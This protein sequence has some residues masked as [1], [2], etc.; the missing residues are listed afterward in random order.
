MH[1]GF[2]KYFMLSYADLRSIHIELT[3]RCNARC[4]M[5]MRNYRGLDY[6][7]G[8]P[9]CE[10]TLDNF[11]K[12]VTPEVLQHLIRPMPHDP[13]ND[14]TFRSKYPG[15]MGLLFNGNLGD[16]ASASDAVDIVEYVSQYNVPVRIQ[17]NGS[18]RS[19]EWWARLA[20]PNVVVGFALDGLADT[21]SL[22][23]QDTDWH[24][25]IRNASALIAAGGRAWWRFIPFDH[26]RHQKQQCEQLSRELGFENFVEIYDGRDTTPVFDR[27]GNFSHSIGVPYSNVDISTLLHSHIANLISVPRHANDIENLKI[28]CIHKKNREIYLA[29][30]GS[31]YPCCFLGFYPKTMNH[32]GN[33]QLSPMVQ[34]NNALEFGLEHCMQWFNTVEQSWSRPSIQQGRLYQCVAS[35]GGRE[36]NATSQAAA[37]SN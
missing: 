17:T 35:C 8:Y 7:S 25:V 36:F 31:I 6:N 23:R 20:F 28:G 2:N 19:P 33:Q 15:F 5:C 13:V 34:E 32:P 3:T 14:G 22:Y 27:R 21:H 4:P 30:D 11:K 16:F 37:K 29:A 24:R 18:A 12:I 9:L 1:T 26:N 10:L